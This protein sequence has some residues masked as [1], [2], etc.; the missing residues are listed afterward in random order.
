MSHPA[1]YTAYA[2]TEKLTPLK[3]I[4]VPWTDPNENQ[5]VVKVKACGVCAGD[6]VPQVQMLPVALPRIPGHEFVGEIVAVGPG[7]KKFN[8]GAIVG[9][10]WHGGQCFDCAQCRVGKFIGC[11]SHMAHGISFDGG[12][13][14][15]VTIRSEAICRI[16]D[17]MAP[18]IAGP[19]LC[20]GVTVFNGLRNVN[21]RPGDIVAVHGIGGLGHLGIQFATKMGYRAVALSSGPAKRADALAFGAIAYLDGSAVDQA[22]ELQKL[23]GA[24]VI[25]LCAPTSAVAPLLQGLAYDGTL[26]VLAAGMEETGVNL[27]SLVANRTTIRGWPSGSAQDSE[28]C[29]AFAQQFGIEPT[30]QRFPLDKAQEAF[31][32]RSS[33]RYRAVI[34]PELKI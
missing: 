21:I 4:T 10:G 32:S 18:E 33:A 20:A 28:D 1:S 30:V 17:G 15:Y 13:A 26:L 3:K 2:F 29:L 31:T 23:G 9:G 7:E 16:P 6:A 22:A 12:Y 11:T 8:V 34:M 5:V 19:L 25:L 24:K 27:F 14:E